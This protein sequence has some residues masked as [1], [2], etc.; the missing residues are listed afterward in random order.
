M[1]MQINENTLKKI[2]AEELKKSDVVDVVKNNK[3]IEKYVK[4]VAADVINNLFQ[5]LFQQK[6]F[7]NQYLTK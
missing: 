4:K 7:I 5:T 1:K 2:I 6:S 3:D